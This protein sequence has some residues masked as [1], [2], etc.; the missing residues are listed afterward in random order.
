MALPDPSIRVVVADD[1]PM[2][3]DSVSRALSENPRLT[4]V[5]QARD[6]RQ[7]LAAIRETR[8]Q[9]A[10][11]D[12]RMPGLDGAQVIDAVV[13]ERLPTRVA[14][15]SAE[16]QRDAAYQI[17][18]LGAAG[19]LSK[20]AEVETL[21]AAVLSL[22]DGNTVISPEFQHLLAAE[23]RA[24]SPDD[25]PTLTERERQVL[26]RVAQGQ[27]VAEMAAAIYLSPSTVKKH[28]DSVYRKLGVSE[29]GAAV[30]EAMRRGLIY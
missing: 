13:Q 28:L 18:A 10:L 7:A 20:G 2:V 30:A 17:L 8:P 5:A 26:E 15:L 19:L 23:I 4:V 25:R 22:A 6:G 1:H 12:L 11:V 21:T 9:V 29:R 27:S 24:R 14:L 3:L 16:L